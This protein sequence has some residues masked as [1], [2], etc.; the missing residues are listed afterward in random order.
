VLHILV[1]ADACPVKNEVYQVAGRYDLRVTL[2]SNMWLRIPE[3]P[4]L[5][6]QVVGDGI[7]AADDWIA[8]QATTGDIVVTADILLADRCLQRG[9]WVLGP[10]GKPFTKDNIGDAVAT[11]DLL[12]H[13]RD[14]GAITGGPAPLRQRDRSRFLQQLDQVIHAVRRAHPRDAT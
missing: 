3:Q 6:L 12:A 2:V 10:T 11:R 8:E 5:A 14:A 13:M 1:D 7:D 9:A 4:R